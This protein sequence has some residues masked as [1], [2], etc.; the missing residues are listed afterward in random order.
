MIDTGQK[1]AS[2]FE[3]P[4][5]MLGLIPDG[6]STSFDRRVLCDIYGG[7][8]SSI[9]NFFFWRETITP[10]SKSN[11]EE[12]SIFNSDSTSDAELSWENTNDIQDRFN[13]GGDASAN[14]EKQNEIY[15]RN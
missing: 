10:D 2:T 8:N 3:V 15:D 1:R 5:I 14:W 11:R 6:I 13:A 9:D 4:G 12:D 7:I